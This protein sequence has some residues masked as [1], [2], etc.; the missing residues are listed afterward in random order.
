MQQL[1]YIKPGLLRWDEVPQPKLED[2]ASALVRPFAVARCD[3]DAAFLRKNIFRRFRLGRLLGLVDFNIADW[4]RPDL[5]KGPFPMGHEC[6]A[7]VMETGAEVSGFFPGD[8]VVIPFQVSCGNCPICA[9]GLTSQCEKYGPFDMY[10]GVGKH[11]VRGGMF[12]DAVL[13]PHA[14]HMLIPLPPDLDPVALASAS[15]NLPDAWSRIAPALL[16]CPGKEVLVVGGSARSIGLYCVAFAAAMGAARVDFLETDPERLQIATSVGGNAL[17]G[18]LT[19]VDRQYDL[20][21]NGTNRPRGGGRIDSL[22]ETGRGLHL[23]EYL[24]RQIGACAFFSALRQ[25]SDFAY[26][27]GQPGGGLAGYA[28]L[29]R[30]EQGRCRCGYYASSRL[31]KRAPGPAGR[32]HQSSD[33]TQPHL[34]LRDVQNYG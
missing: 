16:D 23:N 9:D 32:Y 29:Y 7:E 26:G 19:A 12:S 5:L 31:G 20:V 10:G 6:V 1:T 25:K 21:V 17:N 2:P 27:A 13:V 30:R 34:P 28:A 15:D 22:P 11:T 14:Q 24:F 3:L 18:D 4:M 8:R 33:P